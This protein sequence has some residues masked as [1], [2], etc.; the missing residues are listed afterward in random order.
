MALKLSVVASRVL[1]WSINPNP[2]IVTNTLDSIL[3]S[4]I[5]QFGKNYSFVVCL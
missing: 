4:G 2:S 3:R 1:K 5:I